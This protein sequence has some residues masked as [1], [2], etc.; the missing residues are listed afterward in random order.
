M[1]RLIRYSLYCLMLT[2]LLWQ[3]RTAPG[4][5]GAVKFDPAAAPYPKL[6]SRSRP[7][8]PIMPTRPAMCGCRT[9]YKPP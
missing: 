7:S 1:M 3:C 6:T 5:V 2:A 8:L 9:V 4:N